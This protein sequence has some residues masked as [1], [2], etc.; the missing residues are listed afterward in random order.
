MC[1][2]AAASGHGL[3]ATRER[4]D[5][6]YGISGSLKPGLATITFRNEGKEPHVMALEH[7][8]SGKTAKDFLKAVKSG[9][10]AAIGKLGVNGDDAVG[11]PFVLTPGQETQVVTDNLKPGIYGMLCYFPDA[12]G[13][14]HFA[15]GMVATFTVKGAKFTKAPS[16][17]AEVDRN[18]RA[19]ERRAHIGD[20]QDHEQ[21]LDP[22]L[23]RGRE[24][25]RFRDDRRRQRLLQQRVPGRSVAS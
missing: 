11:A 15:K 1:N 16:A 12:T 10:Q 20:A 8:K 2:V 17:Q 6:A 7:L 21:R 18:Q 19:A 22:A 23:V 4:E 5:Y 13:T 14:P 24:A 25:Q 9:K 3:G